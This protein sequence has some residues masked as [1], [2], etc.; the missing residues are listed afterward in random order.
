MKHPSKNIYRHLFLILLLLAFLGLRIFPI[1]M[2]NWDYP[3]LL[4]LVA[5]VY[6]GIQTKVAYSRLII[7]CTV[8]ILASCVYS[9][10]H[11]GQALYMVVAH[12]YKY[13][14]ILFFFYLVKHQISAR[15]AERLLISVAVICCS[16]YIVQ[17][18]VYP[19]ILFQGAD[20]DSVSEIIYRVR[21]PGS[22]SCYCLFFYGVNRFLLGDRIKSIIYILL[23]FL[24]ILIMGFRSLLSVS[25]VSFF[26]ML[27]FTLKFTVRTFLFGLLGSVAVFFIMQTSLVQSKIEEMNRR[28]EAGQTF[29]NE[30]Y[31]RWRELDY[32]WYKQFK[33]PVEHIVGGGVPTD[34]TSQYAKD[35]LGGAYG[36]SLYWNDLGLVGLSMIIGI[37][38][39]LL[40]VAMYLVCIWR[41]KEPELQYL[42]FTLIVILIGSLFTTAELY[43]SGNILLFSLF[44]YIE[45][46][47]HQERTPKRLYYD[48][49]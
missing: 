40:L 33:T 8:F 29:E 36:M 10:F 26:L 3:L 44:L 9:Y 32:Y 1:R 39:V 24:P 38:A 30:D 6:G 49:R 5:A 19:T 18:F 34:P 23:G 43:R 35:I 14:S 20:S 13:L 47:Y 42:R 41:L 17:W 16:C 28:N 4:V 31:V 11:H 22:I 27:P 37:P 15:T 46:K 2:S 21:I 7:L 48:G 25:F 12:S 45:Y